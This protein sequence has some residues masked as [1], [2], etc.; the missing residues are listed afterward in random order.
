[1]TQSLFPDIRLRRR[2]LRSA[3]CKRACRSSSEVCELDFSR[4]EKTQLKSPIAIPKQKSTLLGAFPRYS[5]EAKIPTLCALQASLQIF[6][7]GM[8]T[9]FFAERKSSA[10]IVDSDSKTKKAPYWVLFCFGAATQIRTGDLILTKDVL[11][12]LSH[13]SALNSAHCLLYQKKKEKS[14]GLCKKNEKNRKSFR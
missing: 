3:P 12:Q 10:R 9:G 7:R 11:Y 5:P 13:S 2:Y 4:S 1:M 14:I 8:R 6:E